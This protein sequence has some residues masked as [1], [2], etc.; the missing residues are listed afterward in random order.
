MDDEIKNYHQKYIKMFF[1]IR[2]NC[3]VGLRVLRK[4]KAMFAKNQ[5]PDVEML[6]TMST[7]ALFTL[8]FAEE[9]EST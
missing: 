1:E 4:G 8:L 3:L 7:I 2:L 9:F 6:Q 5:K